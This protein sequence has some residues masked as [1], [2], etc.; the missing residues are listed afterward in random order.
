MVTA[1]QA[2][3]RKDSAQAAPQQPLSLPS[4]YVMSST[5][6]P[7]DMLPSDLRPSD[8]KP[9]PVAS[10]GEDFRFGQK[11]GSDSFESL[12]G[13]VRVKEAE[14]M[15]FQTKADEALREAEEYH[16]MIRAT[17]EKLEAD[18]AERLNKLRLQE[19]EDR[20]RKKLDELKMLENSHCDY[21]NMKMRMQGEI[22]GLLERMEATKKQWV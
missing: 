11:P 7:R 6:Q 5:L 1:G 12:E 19:T 9:S 14:A 17:T 8:L 15:M 18:Y 21:Y 13:I 16:R 3:Q 20:R 10:S 2:N 22:A 4:K